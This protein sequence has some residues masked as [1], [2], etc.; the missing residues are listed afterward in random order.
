[1]DVTCLHPF[2]SITKKEGCH[3]GSLLSAKYGRYQNNMAAVLLVTTM[4]VSVFCNSIK[5]IFAKN[6]IK[7]QSDNLAF[8]LIGN[9]LCIA[10]IALCGGLSSAHSVTIILGSLFGLL[11]LMASLTFT[12]ALKLGPMSLTSLIVLCGSTLTSTIVNTL[13]FHEPI[14]TGMQLLGIILIIFSLILGSNINLSGGF[15]ALWFI[16]VLVSAVFN[17]SLGIV[18]K[19]QTQSAYP[20]ETMQFLFWTFIFCSLFN[21]VLLVY[22]VKCRQEKVTLTFDK[23]LVSG[24]LLVGAATASIHIINLKLVSMLPSAIFFPV[25]SC[26]RIIL[27]T[28]ADYVIFKTRLSKRQIASLILGFI[29]ILMV[30]GVIH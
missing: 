27:T 3:Y 26:G 5:N 22:R 14:P 6:E 2:R 30:S 18:Q 8:N 15:S 7:N 1:M 13:L 23:R 4:F 24:A 29:A 16:I 28:L 25:N 11:N 21:T 9:V 10:I 19:I 20:T 17:G 12:A